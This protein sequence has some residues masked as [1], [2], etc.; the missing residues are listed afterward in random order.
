[1]TI[2][3]SS[4]QEKVFWTRFQGLGELP[5][6]PTYIL[7]ALYFPRTRECVHGWKRATAV[8]SAIYTPFLLGLAF[9]YTTGIIY[10]RYLPG[11]NLHGLEVVRGPFFWFLT[12]LGFSLVLMASL[13]YYSESRKSDSLHRRR[14]LIFLALAP[15]PMLTA[16][17]VQNLEWSGAV[18]TPQAS[19][20]FVGILG[21]GI[22][23]H[24]LFLDFRFATRR[25]LAH[26]MALFINLPICLLLIAVLR[27]GLKLGFSWSGAVLFLVCSAPLL[28]AYPA[29]VGW[30]KRLL[31][32]RIYKREDRMNTIL[33]ELSRS[34]RTVKDPR[35]LAASV[36]GVVRDSLDL[37]SC[38]LMAREDD[39][40]R[41]RVIGFASHPGHP[42]HEHRG[43]V[44]SGMFA[45]DWG[46]CY[47]FDTPN[48][49]YSS[50]WQVGKELDRGGCRIEYLQLGVLR[51]HQ[52]KGIVRESLWEEDVE[53]ISIPLEVGGERV[54]LLWLGGKMDDSPFS[55]EELDHIVALSAQV[56]A[57][58]LNSCLVQEI[59]DRNRR[60][61]ELA[62][63][64]YSAQ[65]EERIR[66][67]REL[68]DG[69]APYL[70][71]IIYG[72]DVLERE[73]NP[74]ENL[75]VRLEEI[76]TQ[77]RQGLKEL[78]RLITGLR[79]SSLEVLGLRNSLASYLERFG[80]ENGLKVDFQ[81]RGRMERLDPLVETTVFRVA[82]EAL[83]NVAK[84]ARAG[85][86]R[87]S[88]SESDGEIYLEV[89]DDGVGFVSDD[90]VRRDPVAPCLG[91]RNMEERAELAGGRLMVDTAPGRGTRIYLQLPCAGARWR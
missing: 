57:S 91:L 77:A 3:S 72:L 36:T 73:A 38:A 84:H 20:L 63:K 13:L 46:G 41:Y 49:M 60:L 76:R 55:L 18:T 6:I 81:C 21:Y 52:G 89:E 16:N 47:C 78:R 35:A 85:K 1:M 75:S 42:A 48:G 67:S 68:H 82:Q 19:I 14:G 32:R 69:L 86:V 44:D 26:A 43:V 9:L 90:L 11:D 87:L 4:L 39:T 45:Y 10:P 65:E 12:A 51:I 2:A 33:E 80:A 5:L 59:M 37:A 83:S 61:R 24:G 22:M 34:I 28:I 25:A 17:L 54:G 50:Y 30:A 79:P 31:L 88:L 64:V 71:D 40:G 66:V 8:I 58:L 29:V 27:Y 56:A 15:F 7:L 23:R 74:D 53:A 62:H 70:L